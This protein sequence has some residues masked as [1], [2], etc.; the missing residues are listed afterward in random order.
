MSVWNASIDHVHWPAGG[1]STPFSTPFSLKADQGKIWIRADFLPAEQPSSWTELKLKGTNW[2]GFQSTTG[3]PHEL[4]R[5]NVSSYADFLTNHNFNAV[6]LP[7]SAPVVTWALYGERWAAQAGSHDNC[8]EFA[9]CGAYRSNTQCGS[10][11]GMLSLEILDD[12]I[13]RLMA[14]ASL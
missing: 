9:G 11:D 3:C 7:L 8:V 10:Y 1:S 2:A 12:V 6:R 13:N 4:W 14:E 5:H